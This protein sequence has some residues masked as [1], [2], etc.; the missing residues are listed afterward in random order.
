LARN[1]RAAA[2]MARLRVG[3]VT[4]VPALVDTLPGMTGGIAERAP[5]T[6]Q[7]IALN[8]RGLA[9]AEDVSATPPAS[10]LCIPDRSQR[11]CRLHPQGPAWELRSPQS[12]LPSGIAVPGIAD[13][14]HAARA[15]ETL[16]CGIG[17]LRQL[18]SRLSNSESLLGR[19]L[20]DVPNH[21]FRYTVAPDLSRRANTPKHTAFAHASGQKLAWPRLPRFI[22][23]PPC[24]SK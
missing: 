8:T 16:P 22:S 12:P 20:D 9:R 21:A 7:R 1:S 14:W 24:P 6:S 10:I 17:A 5:N 2:R 15:S 18:L 19:I 3:R 4:V 13:R 11:R 23:G